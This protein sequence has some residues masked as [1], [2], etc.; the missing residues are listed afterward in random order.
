MI[1]KLL[2]TLLILILLLIPFKVIASQDI[3]SNCEYEIIEDVRYIKL[4]SVAIVHKLT[5]QW[6]DSDKSVRTT[7]NDKN[8]I[9]DTNNDIVYI[10]DD[11]YYFVYDNEA[12]MNTGIQRSSATPQGAWTTT[13]PVNFP[14]ATPKKDL[15]SIMAAHSIPYIATASVAYPEDFTRKLEKSKS[16]KGFKFFHFSRAYRKM[17]SISYFE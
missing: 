7:Y 12:Y 14:K 15:L 5:L 10:N 13:T 11:M 6:S 16:I 9:F 3:Y 4:S 17:F 8:L 1:K 2:R